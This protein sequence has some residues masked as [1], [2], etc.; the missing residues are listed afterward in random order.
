V[1]TRIVKNQSSDG[2]GFGTARNWPFK[3]I[4]MVVMVC[5]AFIAM[6]WKMWGV[7]ASG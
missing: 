2:L 7:G 1:L 4:V 6:E 3:V 5:I